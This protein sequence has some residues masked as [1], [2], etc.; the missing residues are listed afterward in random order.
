[1]QR[2]FA[3]LPESVAELCLV[4]LRI[5]TRGL[6]ARVFAAGLG[7][8]LDRSAAEAI[9]SGAG[10]MGSEWFAMGRGSAS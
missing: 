7:R 2:I 8:A 4:R 10:L 1:M 6:S 3:A 5:Q 9:A